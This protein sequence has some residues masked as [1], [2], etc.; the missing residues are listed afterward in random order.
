MCNVKNELLPIIIPYDKVSYKLMT[1]GLGKV[2]D[3]SFVE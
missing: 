3:K 2:G 1:M